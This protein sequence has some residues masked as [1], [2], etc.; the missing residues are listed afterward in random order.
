[1]VFCSRRRRLSPA[2][3]PDEMLLPSVAQRGEEKNQH[4]CLFPSG[5]KYLY[6]PQAVPRKYLPNSSPHVGGRCRGGSQTPLGKLPG[7]REYFR[8]IF[9]ERDVNSIEQKVRGA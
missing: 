6:R 8:K 5:H 2:F 1:M 7:K 4:F 9:L 3:R